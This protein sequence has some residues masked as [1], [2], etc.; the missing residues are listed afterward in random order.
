MGVVVGCL[1]VS[2]GLASFFG[3]LV[4]NAEADHVTGPIWDRDFRNKKNNKKQ[5]RWAL[6]VFSLGVVLC[7]V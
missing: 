7:F 3:C 6:S 1:L 4:Q 2:F 5:A